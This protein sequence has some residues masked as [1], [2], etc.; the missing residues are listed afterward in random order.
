MKIYSRKTEITQQD[1]VPSAPW[2]WSKIR[3][4]IQSW[5]S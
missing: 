2:P 1:L 4:L 5:R 3:Y